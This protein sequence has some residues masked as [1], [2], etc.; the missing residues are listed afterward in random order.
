MQTSL[1]RQNLELA[2]CPH[3]F[4]SSS[5]YL[6]AVASKEDQNKLGLGALDLKN[7][8]TT[9]TV[10]SFDDCM[11]SMLLQCCTI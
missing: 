7:N 5:G 1:I 4:V 9:A 10:V 3:D 11:D 6:K 8:I 2:G